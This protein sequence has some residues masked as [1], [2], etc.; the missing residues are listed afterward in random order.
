MVGKDYAIDVIIH[1]AE[2]FYFS[3][4]MNKILKATLV[5]NCYGIQMRF[6]EKGKYLQFSNSP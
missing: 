5:F 1:S 2:V 6:H 3:L 4:D